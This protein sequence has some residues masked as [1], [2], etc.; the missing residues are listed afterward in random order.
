MSYIKIL[1][2]LFSFCSVAQGAEVYRCVTPEG[3]VSFQ[4]T[5]CATGGELIETGEVQTA[6]EPLRK[7]ELKLFKSYL[8]EDEQN[9]QAKIRAWQEQ[10]SKV[11]SAGQTRSCWNKRRQYEKAR[12]RLRSGCKPSEGAALRRKRDSAED[13]I[14]GYCHA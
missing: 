1:L 13:F 10:E 9:Y 2:F 6:W 5:A 7:A 8:Q 12:A 11:T 14:Q 4:Q 3:R